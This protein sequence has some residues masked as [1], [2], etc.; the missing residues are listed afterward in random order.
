M[1]THD[2]NIADKAKEGGGDAV[3]TTGDFA[4]QIATLSVANGNAYTTGNANLVGNSAYFSAN[5]N[6]FATQ[7][8][9]PIMWR[10]SQYLVI[11]YLN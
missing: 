10:N 7:T 11:K 8:S 4:R 9:I 5:T 3:I 2:S 6:A 1:A